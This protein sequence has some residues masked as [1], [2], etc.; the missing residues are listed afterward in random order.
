MLISASLVNAW[1]F[2]ESFVNLQQ[3]REIWV[4]ILLTLVL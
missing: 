3:N 2:G 1:R 4:K